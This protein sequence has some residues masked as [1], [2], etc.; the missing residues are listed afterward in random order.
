[1]KKYILIF[2]TIASFNFISCGE[3]EDP[4][5]PDTVIDSGGLTIELE[6][7]S[8]GSFSDAISAA[9]LELELTIDDEVLDQSISTTRFESVSL[10]NFLAD[11]NYSVGVDVFSISDDVTFTVFVKGV[12]SETTLEYTGSFDSEDDGASFPDFLTI[13][14]SGDTYTIQR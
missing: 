13:T 9:D 1:M 6:W 5:P 4:L 7:S 12:E 11:A 2:L 8:G 10:S 3:D 14:K